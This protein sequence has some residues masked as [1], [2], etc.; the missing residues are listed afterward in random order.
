MAHVRPQIYLGTG[1]ALLFFIFNFLYAV[2]YINLKFFLAFIPLI[3]LVFINELY[4]FNKRPFSSI[5]YTFLGI[6]Y[7]AFPL[8]LFNYFVFSS[9]VSLQHL[10]TDTDNEVK[11]DIINK[12]IHSF[13]FLK[14]TNE[15]IYSPNILLGYFILLWIFDTAAYLI[16]ITLGKHRLF[17]KISPKKSWE[18][19]AG[20]VIITAGAAYL[21][22]RF[23]KDLT[24][25]NWLSIAAIIVIIGTYGDL[26]ESMFKRSINLK[27]SGKI[28]PGHGG[29]LDRFDTLF[30][31]APIVFVY[32]QF[33]S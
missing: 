6:I 13:Y 19:F 29:I 1:I 11:V 10:I 33:Y 27:D 9:G 17:E 12:L 30:L 7:V 28:L 21:L 20:G 22:S 4:S 32:L 18:G 24:L 8:S 5:A 16:G 14:P 31:S 15:I 25:F 23:F 3:L 2:D 26:V